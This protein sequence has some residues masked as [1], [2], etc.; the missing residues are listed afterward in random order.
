MAAAIGFILGQFIFEFFV[1]G[2]VAA[3]V[4]IA[5]LPPTRRRGQIGD[6]LLAW[7]VLFSVGCLHLVNFI[8]HVFLGAM[9]ARFIGWADSPFQ[10]ELGFASLGFSLVGFLAWRGGYELRLAAVL[11]PAV[12]LLGAGVGHIYQ[13]VE[14]GNHALGNSGLLLWM[15]FIT[16]LAGILFL[17]MARPRAR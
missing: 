5:R 11:G 17:A 9:S 3:V 4:T 1:L 13:I 6:R 16:P 7:Y 10:T 2:L 15:D 12:F 14:H 8:Y